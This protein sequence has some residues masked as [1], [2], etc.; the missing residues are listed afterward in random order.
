MVEK[1][2][3][4]RLQ[5]YIENHRKRSERQDYLYTEEREKMQIL[6]TDTRRF[7]D[8]VTVEQEVTVI[9]GRGRSR[10]QNTE[11]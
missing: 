3:K 8:D 7:N 5:H 6:N 9:R 4:I 11:I 10:R 1:V 2:F